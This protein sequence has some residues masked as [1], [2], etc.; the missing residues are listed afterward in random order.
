VSQP[1]TG[2]GDDERMEYWIALPFAD[3]QLSPQLL[4][5]IAQQAEALGF[6]GAVT[7]DHIAVPKQFI[8][9][10]GF[11]YECLTTLAFLAAKTSTLRLGTSVVVAPLRNPVVLAK[12]VAT[13]DVISEG[14]ITIGLAPGYS[15][16]EFETLGA[17]FST[18][19]AWTDE[20]IAILR[21]LYAG[22]AEPYRGRFFQLEDYTFEPLPPQGAALPILVGGT[23][24]AALKRAAAGADMWQSASISSDEF[25]ACVDRLRRLTAANGRSVQPGAEVRMGVTFAANGLVPGANFREGS[26]AEI[27]E[28]VDQWRQAGAERLTIGFPAPRFLSMME[29]FAAAVIAPA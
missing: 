23:S 2:A 16:L 26:A 4:V 8:D 21:H 5:E 25:S 3:R 12:Q 9:R 6:A 7:G 24:E 19:G 1:V 14:R 13:L 22:T 28:Q 11:N 20:T 18:R 17:D 10:H 29:R 15:E 27:R